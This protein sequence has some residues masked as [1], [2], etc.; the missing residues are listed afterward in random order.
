MSVIDQIVEQYGDNPFPC[1]FIDK[2][3]RKNVVAYDREKAVRWLSCHGVVTGG[4]AM[5][6]LLPDR[7]LF[8]ELLERMSYRCFEFLPE[9]CV[10]ISL[11]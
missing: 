7:L 5:V 1:T 8:E 9:D 11:S 6:E 4:A 3:D 2:Y 10:S